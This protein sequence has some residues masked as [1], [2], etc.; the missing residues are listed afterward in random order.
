MAA[1]LRFLLAA[2]ACACPLASITDELNTGIR[3]RK[4]CDYMA[5]LTGI[6]ASIYQFVGESYLQ[7]HRV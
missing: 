2:P 3:F 6:T 1:L 5:R 4:F 7:N